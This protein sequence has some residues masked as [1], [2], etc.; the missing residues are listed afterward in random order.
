MYIMTQLW[1]YIIKNKSI[2]S[3][4]FFEWW[5]MVDRYG[6][7][8]PLKYTRMH[9]SLIHGS[10]ATNETVYYTWRVNNLHMYQ[11]RIKI[12]CN[13]CLSVVIYIYIY[14]VA[15]N[16][17]IKFCTHVF[18]SSMQVRRWA[19]SVQVFVKLP[20]NGTFRYFD[21]LEHIFQPNSYKSVTCC[22]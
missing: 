11:G 4:N 14:I 19:I 7:F 1:V 9:L 15:T 12:R 13:V 6:W 20:Y 5:M 8:R 17:R 3:N 2:P 10:F 16:R 18:F 22:F 21:D